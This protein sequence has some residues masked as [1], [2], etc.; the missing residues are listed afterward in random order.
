MSH[1]T[2]VAGADSVW[3]MWSGNSIKHPVVF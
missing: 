2:A 1:V 3:L